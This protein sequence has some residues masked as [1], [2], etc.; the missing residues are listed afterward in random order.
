MIENNSTTEPQ[1]DVHSSTK[2]QPVTTSS[3]TP[4]SDSELPDTPQPRTDDYDEF[5]KRS[6][7]ARALSCA[8]TKVG[9]WDDYGVRVLTNEDEEYASI[10]FRV[11]PALPASSVDQL[12]VF[13]VQRVPYTERDRAWDSVSGPT[14]D[15]LKWSGFVDSVLAAANFARAAVESAVWAHARGEEWTWS[16]PVPGRDDKKYELWGDGHP[17]AYDPEDDY[18]YYDD[19]AYWQKHDP[20]GLRPM[21]EDVVF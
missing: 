7:L 16:W 6:P 19:D 1:A 3:A 21:P 5:L 11:P 13:A 4:L 18:V 15:Y 17:N 12:A 20:L 2:A 8:M 14:S 9:A 10:H